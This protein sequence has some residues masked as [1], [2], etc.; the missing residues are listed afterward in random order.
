MSSIT[1]R[2]G[3]R[4]QGV[5]AGTRSTQYLPHPCSRMPETWITTNTIAAS[6]PVTA[7]FPVGVRSHAFTGKGNSPH[8]FAKRMKK[9]SVQ[10]NPR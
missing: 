7:R 4:N 9:K 8:T 5:P 6:A 1:K 10:K 3:H 2:S